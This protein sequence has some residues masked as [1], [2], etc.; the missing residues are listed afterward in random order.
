MNPNVIN[1]YFIDYDIDVKNGCLLDQIGISGSNT[2]ADLT[3][4][5]G[6]GNSA[7]FNPT[8]TQSVTSC[9]V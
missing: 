7:T 5:I 8:W 6:S 4:I 1:N 9:P 3:Y 2:V